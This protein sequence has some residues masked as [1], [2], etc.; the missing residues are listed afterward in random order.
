MAGRRGQNSRHGPRGP[1][2]DAPRAADAAT[3]RR[4]PTIGAAAARSRSSAW[5]A[6]STSRCTC[7]CATRTRRASRRSPTLRDGETAQVEGVVTDGR[8]QFRPRRQLVVQHRRRRRRPGAALPAL[9]SRRSRR[10]SPPAQRVRVRGEARGGFFGLE[11]VH[12]S[13]KVVDADTPLASALTPVYPTSAQLPQAYLRKAVG[14]RAGARA[15]LD[16]VLP[17]DALPPGLPALR[18]ALAFLHHPP[19][20]VGAG[21]ARGPQRTRRGSASSS[22]SCWRSSCRSCRPARARAPARAARSRARRGGLQERLLAALPFALT[23]GA[24]R[25]GAR[26]RAPTSAGA[27]ADAPAAAGRRR[28]GQDGGRRARRGASRSTPA[29]SAR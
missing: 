6:T 17:A 19:P 26:D 25:V 28:L 1:R 29:G 27:R 7:R 20:D 18:D 12:P 21:R 3:R 13:F 15:D 2:A 11:M 4:R 22:R 5:C 24:A 9:L 10:R 16:E 23:R 8:V 14:A